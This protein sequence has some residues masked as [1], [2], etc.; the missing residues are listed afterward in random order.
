MNV[1]P[2]RIFVLWH[3]D[4]PIGAQ[5]AQGIFDWFRTPDSHGIQVHY[6][7]Q[8]DPRRDDGLPPPM[9][10]DRATLNLVVVLAEPKMVRDRLWRQWLSEL[11]EENEIPRECR[12]AGS[13]SRPG[14]V[15]LYPVA[16]HR[17]AYNLPGPIRALNFISPKG[18]GRGNDAE[19]EQDLAAL[20]RNLQT[21]L[22]E[23]FARLL[24]Q[25]LKEES[26]PKGLLGRMLEWFHSLA[27]RASTMADEPPKVKVFLSHAKR[28]GTSVAKAIRDYIYQNT[29]LSAFFDENDIALG[30]K[31]A[32][33]LDDSLEKDSVAMVSVNSDYYSSRPWCRREIQIFSKPR[34]N[35]QDIWEKPAVLV[36]QSMSGGHVAHAI[37]EFGNAPVLRWRA[38]DEAL[39][40]DTLLR[41][42]IFRS[43]H[44]HVAWLIKN[45][46]ASRDPRRNR[47]FINWAPDPLG[48][49]L[50]IRQWE[51]NQLHDWEQ[52]VSAAKEAK[53]KR[54]PRP[55]LRPLDVIYPGPGMS[56][57]ELE[58]LTERFPE[59]SLLSFN[60]AR[61]MP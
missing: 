18:I 16:L 46:L 12:R 34:R 59:V 35:D 30:F 42:T 33:V 13:G 21:R 17:T 22:T 43:Y 52:A 4:Y 25:K 6:R 40:I 44:S 8:P 58:S 29:Q 41:E 20:L 24:T 31:F 47:V 23:A 5:I 37:P 60:E 61:P 48:L 49:E 55:K 51:Q 38:D 27:E 2:A 9:P 54:P 53:Q 26:S 50:V 7:S 10:L 3:P 11:A 32:K 14:F 39:C 28:D 57:I 19:I 15:K 45:E 36:V 1:T 56:T